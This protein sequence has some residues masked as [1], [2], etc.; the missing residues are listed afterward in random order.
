MEENARVP[1]FVFPTALTFY[2][3]SRQ[4]HKQILSLY[5]PYEV[6]VEFVGKNIF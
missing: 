6:P 2:T 1:V 5:N 4:T 3:K